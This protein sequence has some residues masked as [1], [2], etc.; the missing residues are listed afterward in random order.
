M[1]RTILLASTVIAA[2]A[3][4]A[5]DVEVKK[6][7]YAGPFAVHKP[8]MIDSTDVNSKKFSKSSF[9]NA[10]ID[11]KA[12]ANGRTID[13]GTLP[14]DESST[15]IHL[16][17]FT[18]ANTS[19][20][21]ATI[22]INGIKNYQL[23]VDGKKNNNGYVTLQPSVHKIVVKYLSTPESTDSA[24]IKVDGDRL[25]IGE[26]NA[27]VKRPYNIYDAMLAKSYS[28]VSVSPNGKY[29]I[30]RTNEPIAGG[31]STTRV[32]L[33]NLT[34][35]QTTE[36][37]HY[38][39]W[40]P[41]TN[42]CYY[43]QKNDGEQTYSLIAINPENQAE[44][45]LYRNLP[46]SQFKMSA[47]EDFIIYTVSEE[48]PKE[49]KEIFEVIEP[50]DRQPNW[51]KRS[52][53]FKCDLNT[54]LVQQL[55]FGHHDTWVDDISNDG[56]YLLIGKK[57]SHLEAR[58]TTVTSIYRINL[59]TL[60]IDTLI[61]KDGF[62]S[63]SS[64]SPDG[65]QVI[66]MGTP[67]SL[68]GIGLN[69]AEGQ[70][71]SMIDN[72][73]F[74]SPKLTE[75]GNYAPENWTPITRTFNPSITSF[76]WANADGLIYAN[77][78]DKD[79]KHLY[80]YNTKTGKWQYIDC[81][82]ELM[83][84][85]SISKTSPVMAYYGQGASNSDRLYVM[86]TKS[87]KRTMLDDIDKDRYKDIALGKCEAWNYINSE[88]DT[89]CC[90]YYLPA[91]FDA[92]KQYP[93]IVNYYGGCSPTSRN[94]QSR[95]PQHAYAS[96]GYVVLVIN[97]RGATGF[98]QKWSAAHVNTAGQGVADDII[99]AVKTFC[100]EHS[101]INS[102]KIGCIGASYGGFMT[103][104]LQTVTDIFAAA[105]SHAGISDHTS[106]WGEGYWGYS[107][108]E[109]S[110]ANSYPWTRKDL[111]VDQS[112]L[113]N[114]DKVHTPLLFV[115]GTDDTNVPVGESIQMY[116]ALKLLGRPTAMVL[117]KGENHWIMDY[118]KRLQWQ[119]SI[120]AWFAKYLQ[121]DNT[122]WDSMYSKKDL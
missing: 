5:D 71:A 98:G 107:Y 33:R 82:E 31:G 65:S 49:K 21:T 57:E 29:I 1:K 6:L 93:M 7:T 3:V 26:L 91:D 53:V 69:I 73:L 14:T 110:M 87:L 92:S 62:I 111:Y 99:G 108:S 72:Q 66:V 24:S 50:D 112:P 32:Y 12:L 56:R 4:H 19:Y 105:V 11:F 109:V 80:R 78:E 67:E 103:Q 95:Y 63:S 94:F 86:N 42:K 96:L 115:H 60:H 59:T 10:A 85:I 23:Y 37:R 77:T 2:A 101:Y 83:E 120:W 54:G 34:T 41:R 106:Y 30:Y 18:L 44:E 58:P 13:C 81:G 55:T 61:N 51:R 75:S 46:T 114:A 35:G 90:R 88:G 40:M 25:T 36:K 9:L 122:W 20:T 89:V 104:Y 16:L 76:N 100:K 118:N 28:G 74:L 8:I 119:N 79:Y 52:N 47:T 102:K 22:T 38:I 113:Y 121:D 27:S 43:T 84:H 45:V 39:Y 97:P 117:V 15:A 64:F 48:G 68:G 17:G 116:T 70:T